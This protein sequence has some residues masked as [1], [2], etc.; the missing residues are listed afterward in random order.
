MN[1]EAV[2]LE[3]ADRVVCGKQGSMFLFSS[4]LIPEDIKKQN[5]ASGKCE[6]CEGMKKAMEDAKKKKWQ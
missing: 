5:M 6:Q 2:Y 3:E 1:C 4:D